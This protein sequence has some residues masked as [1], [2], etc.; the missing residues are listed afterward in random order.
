MVVMMALLLLN[1]SGAFVCQRV[2]GVMA[3]AGRTSFMLPER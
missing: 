1:K 3:V 2:A